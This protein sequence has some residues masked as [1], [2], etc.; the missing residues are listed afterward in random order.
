MGGSAPLLGAAA[1]RFAIDLLSPVCTTQRRGAIA[2]RLGSAVLRIGT[3]L[4]TL[5]ASWTSCTLCHVG[6][7]PA[8][9]ALT[10]VRT[11]PAALAWTGPGGLRTI[12]NLA[13]ELLALLGA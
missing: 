7:L 2:A 8:L 13:A 9:S 3:L 1:S 11:L 12:G 5:P 10:D 6:T 4:A